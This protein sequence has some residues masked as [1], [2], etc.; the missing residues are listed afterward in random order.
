M[1]TKS[2]TKL[3]LDFHPLTTKR[4]ADFESLFG[5]RGA[6]G[7]CWCMA[8]RLKRSEFNRQKGQ[9]NKD[10]M[11]ALVQAREVPG[12]LAYHEDRPIGWIALAPRPTYVVLERSRVL[13]PVDE[14]PVWSIS[15]FFIAKDYR[16]KG[17]T[18]QL[19]KAAADYV[20][21]Q[22]GT[23]I[24]GYPVE[25]KMKNMPDVFAW[26]GLPS[27]FHKAGFVECAR[28]SPTR[29]IMRLRLI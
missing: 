29:P 7:G 20:R 10:A 12:I 16:K 17:V 3:R 25:P 6:C 11:K 22:G 9:G 23:V 5:A 4:W 15:C 13:K 21:E 27:A 18:V 26:T 1:A 8:W 2:R 19:L 14:E 28:R 24:E